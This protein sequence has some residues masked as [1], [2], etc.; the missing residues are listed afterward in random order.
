MLLSGQGRGQ[1]GLSEG[2]WAAMDGPVLAVTGTLDGGAKGQDWRWKTEP[3]HHAPAGDK[4]LAVL[5]EADHFLGGMTDN[6]PTPGHPAQR[7]AVSMLTLAFLDAHLAD[8]QNARAWLTALEDRI[9]D[10]P[11]QFMR[12]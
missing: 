6:D 1:Q 11:A 10:W 7:E 12:K 4:Y 5:E 3:F 9:A 8:D 2:S